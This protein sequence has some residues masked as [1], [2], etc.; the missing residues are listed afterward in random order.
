MLIG[1]IYKLDNNI[2][3]DNNNGV[4]SHNGRFLVIHVM[5]IYNY[6]LIFT[7]INTDLNLFY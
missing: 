1:L 6:E 2:I 5:V 4:L 3:I 7:I